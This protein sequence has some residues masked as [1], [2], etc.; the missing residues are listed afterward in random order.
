MI[1]FV[2]KQIC[3]FMVYHVCSFIVI[4]ITRGLNKGFE[5]VL[6]VDRVVT[7]FKVSASG[8]FS[9]FILPLACT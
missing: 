5:L 2:F 4:N 7:F 1:S 6:L 3:E 8:S 9:L